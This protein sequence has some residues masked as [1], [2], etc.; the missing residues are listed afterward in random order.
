MFR[1]ILIHTVYAKGANSNWF[2]PGEARIEA[3]K[4]PR[5]FS[6]KFTSSCAVKADQLLPLTQHP[7][8]TRGK[9]KSLEKVSEDIWNRASHRSLGWIFRGCKTIQNQQPHSWESH[10]VKLCFMFGLNTTLEPQ[11]QGDFH[12]HSCPLK[13]R[14]YTCAHNVGT[15][16]PL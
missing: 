6:E 16:L 4:Q 15:S 2:A 10:K 3:N 11:L 7:R 13:Q 5:G 1:P 12:L 14:H 8:D 9:R